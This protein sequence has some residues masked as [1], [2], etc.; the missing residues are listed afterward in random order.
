[1]N[2]E[3]DRDAA[4]TG[5]TMRAC[6]PGASHRSRGANIPI[7]SAEEEAEVARRVAIYT[8]QIDTR[9]RIAWL[10]RKDDRDT[11]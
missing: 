8:R 7:H 1:M 2:W 9:G 3:E 6:R 10:P 5:Q 4:V 11:P